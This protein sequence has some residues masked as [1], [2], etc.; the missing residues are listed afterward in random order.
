[1]VFLFIGLAVGAAWVNWETSLQ[2]V[3]V[4]NAV[5]AFW[6]NGVL[7]NFR[8][9]PHGAP[10]WAAG[11]SMLTVLGSVVLLIVAWVQ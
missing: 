1:M 3:A 5:A 4:I 7:A 2:V 6:S 9:D 11:L 10:D 8:G